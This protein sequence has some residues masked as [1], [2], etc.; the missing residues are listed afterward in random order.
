M[1]L[2]VFFFFSMTFPDLNLFTCLSQE[3][4]RGIRENL[5]NPISETKNDLFA[6]LSLYFLISNKAIIIN[7]CKELQAVRKD[8]ER[9]CSAVETEGLL[10]AW[11]VA[12]S[13]WQP[14]FKEPRECLMIN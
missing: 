1:E 4:H 6:F 14:E 13:S 7:A 12:S 5:S 9:D 10:E 2:N 11:P 3:D 8:N